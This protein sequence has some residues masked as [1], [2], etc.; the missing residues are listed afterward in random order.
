VRSR[1]GLPL[2]FLL[3]AFAASRGWASSD[4][5]RF[6]ASS[7]PWFWQFIDPTLLKHHL[8][9]SLWY[10]HAQPPL[11]NL[12]LGI[13]LKLFGSSFDTAAADAQLVLGLAIAA[14]L[15][16]VLLRVGLTR[17][18][19]TGVAALF[20]VS[21]EAI[22]YENW[23]FYEYVVTALLLLA[24]VSFVL[25]ER[26][27]ST[28]RAFAVFGLLALLCYTRA[29]FQVTILVVALLFMLFAFREH[30]REIL[31]GAALPFAL[32]LALSVKNWVL[33]GTASTS[34]WAGM[35]LMEVDQSGFRGHELADLQRRGI[36]SPIS[37]IPA[38]RP[39]S[40][41]AGVVPP[42]RRFAGIPVLAD[43]TKPSAS[44]TP[45]FNN[46]EYVDISNRYLHDF[47]QVLV[48]DPAA[49]LRGVWDGLRLAVLPSSD[50]AFFDANR[51]KMHGWTRG[52][53]TAVL[54]QAGSGTAWGI[55]LWYVAGLVFGLWETVRVLRRRGGSATLAFVWLLMAY[56]TL[57][58][59]FGEVEENQR[60]R[61]VSDP[62]VLVLAAVLVARAVARAPA[63]R[64]E[65]TGENAGAQARLHWPTER[66]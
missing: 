10:F 38:F 39:L 27:P 64:R 40:D 42:D 15:Y 8:A 37:S 20:V 45:N 54:W 55:V 5:V 34:S 62:L 43:V 22:L 25:F 19:A 53:D 33:F 58:L 18:W 7:L 36:V 24:A 51:E 52:Y 47:L 49:Y 61:F 16:I 13:W 57:V 4:G 9:Q 63:A 17:W 56:A 41:Y 3:L 23:L 50:Y 66:P 59:T 21:P 1:H 31:L 29:S 32:V 35:N 46:I 30:R 28:F 11:Y 6:D 65:L 26:Q 60:I 14:S 44:D 2:A 12:L 48:H